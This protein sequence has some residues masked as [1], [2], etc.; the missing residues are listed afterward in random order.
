VTTCPVLRHSSWCVAP[1]SSCSSSPIGTSW[2]QPTHNVTQRCRLRLIGIKPRYRPSIIRLWCV[3]VW[4]TAGQVNPLTG[5]LKPQSNGP[6]YSNTVIGTLLWPTWPLMDGLL[7]LVQRWGAWAG[8]GPAQ[9]PPRCT[10]C[11]S[12]P[13]NGQ[14][15]NFQ[16]ITRCGNIIIFALHL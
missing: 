1:P 5:T 9:F 11:N 15:A 10:K 4:W 6:L 3:S 12:P 14:S 7:H 2:T 8:C 16:L 13:T